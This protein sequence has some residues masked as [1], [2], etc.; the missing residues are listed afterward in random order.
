MSTQTASPGASAHE[1]VNTAKLSTHDLGM[2]FHR[3][4]ET[5]PV[6]ENINL[7]VADGEFVCLLGPS[8]CGKSTLL[9]AMAGFLSPSSGEIKVDGGGVRKPEPRLMFVFQEG[10]VFPWLT[11]EDNIGFGLSKLT[12]AEREQRVAH[13][14]KMVGLEG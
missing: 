9:N 5:I 3:G 11:V 8:G 10:G 1:S 6:L 13:Y 7:A 2:V 14:V 4:G 12:R